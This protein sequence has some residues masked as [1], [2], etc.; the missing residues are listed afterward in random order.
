MH[1]KHLLLLVAGLTWIGAVAPARAKPPVSWS[2]ASVEE[3]IGAGETRTLA[4]A[5][6]TERK[7][8]DAVVLVPPA[9]QGIVS[10]TP[11]AL[12]DLAKNQ[13]VVLEL[14]IAPP[15]TTSPGT[16]RGEIQLVRGE[17]ASKKPGKKPAKKAS[18]K[19]GKRAKR[20]KAFDGFLPLALEIGR[21]EPVREQVDRAGFPEPH[22]PGAPGVLASERL[23]RLLGPTPDLNRVHYIRTSLPG[24]TPPRIV[25]ILIP[26]FLGGA[27]N[28]NFFAEDLVR[29]FEGELEVW[30]V[31]RRPNQL[32]DRR[33]ARFALENIDTDPDALAK[34][35]R[36][37]FPGSDLDGDGQPD[38]AFPLP[39]ASGG[40]S[41][42][43][44]FTQDDLRFMAYWGI[45]TYVRDWKLL[46]DDARAIVGDDGL[47]LFGGHSMGTAWAGAFASYD[48]DPDLAV[49]DAAHE[50][51]DGV[52]FL[53]GA[54]PG[55]GTPG[56]LDLAGYKATIAD[57]ATPG[58]PDVYLNSLFGLIDV[59]NLGA[60]AELAGLAGLRSPEAPSIV[61]RTPFGMGLSLVI[62]ARATNRGIVGF[63]LDDD[64][65]ANPAFRA[66]M[67]F[68]DDGTNGFVPGLGAFVP[69]VLPP[70]SPPRSWKDFDDPTLPTCPP[71]TLDD[72]TGCAIRDLGPK[73]GPGE[74]PRA[75]GLQREV[76]DLDDVLST[77][78][79]DS[80]FSEWYFVSGRVDTDFEFFGR[81]SN[82]LFDESLIAITQL[83]RI[84]RPFLA[85]GGSNG[86]APTES[87]FDSYFDFMRI[88]EEAVQR[89]I[90]EGYAHL[91]V[92]LA[93]DNET[94]P[95]V[96][97]WIDTL[98][99]RK[100][101]SGTTRPCPEP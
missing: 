72:G 79:G 42:F 12:G 28:F 31:D 41:T 71:G 27:S 10:V 84:N 52:L 69:A 100:L 9:L 67:G 88:C 82:Q 58:G 61:Q 94:I 68:S 5:F 14:E 56:V 63:F 30:A 48:F 70:G 78:F 59:Q 25:L 40:T 8:K 1:S 96:S 43:V 89:E 21:A 57:L 87:A 7:L 17:K 4:I 49:V 53:E 55:R 47:V 44:D 3:S 33:G 35:T 77:L 81:F 50:K 20:P 54:G 90:I 80:N 91:D 39:D 37:Y 92:V 60:G 6:T 23:Q 22:T 19:P 32:E 74:A 75:W 38:G 15:S 34:A 65:S 36:F 26:G 97:D 73:P 85:I 76:S 11:S 66:S 93:R 86:L 24:P 83:R 95:L 13:T 46:V 99:E 101:L 16:L 2:P 29:T 51:I 62:P 64:F 98:R 45:D 18:N